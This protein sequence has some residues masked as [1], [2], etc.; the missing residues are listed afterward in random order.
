MDDGD[1]DRRKT[2]STAELDWVGQVMGGIEGMV[3]TMEENYKRVE[4]HRR[5][6][7]K[8]L[9][10]VEGNMMDLGKMLKMGVMLLKAD[11][12]ELRKA[13]ERRRE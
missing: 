11:Q 5:G 4:S 8:R 9:K 13:I 2:R 12:Y 6:L 3:R 1:K 10:A 7:E